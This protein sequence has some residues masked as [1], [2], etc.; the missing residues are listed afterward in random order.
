MAKESSAA[1][2]NEAGDGE[3]I[4]WKSSGVS[5]ETRKRKHLPQ[6]IRLS[7]VPK[8]YGKG[9]SDTSDR[10]TTLHVMYMMIL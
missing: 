5:R 10:L 3:V 2:D 4:T 8:E 9:H 6:G 7:R 1:V